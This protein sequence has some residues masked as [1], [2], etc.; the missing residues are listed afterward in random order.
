[1]ARAAPAAFAPDAARQRIGELS[2][3]AAAV[4]N[5]P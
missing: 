5:R 3:A 1:L 4:P 2:T